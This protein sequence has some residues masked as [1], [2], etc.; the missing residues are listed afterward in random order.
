MFR[1]VKRAAKFERQQENFD[2][3]KLQGPD[4]DRHESLNK[5]RQEM[6]DRQK[7]AIADLK[8]RQADEQ[9]KI[10]DKIRDVRRA[11]DLDRQQAHETQRKQ[12]EEYSRKD[13]PRMK[14]E[15]RP[16]G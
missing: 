14:L 1:A 11:A 3:S 10:E 13:A 5:R 4:K 16:G 2:A 6:R 9:E 8:Q 15:S 7:A 12:L